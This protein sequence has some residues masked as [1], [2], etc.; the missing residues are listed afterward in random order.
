MNIQ[1]MRASTLIAAAALLPLMSL[2]GAARA[3]VSP[4]KPY[5]PVGLFIGAIEEGA[6]IFTPVR[7]LPF[8]HPE[9][10]Q[11]EFP[12]V[13]QLHG[14]EF[15]ALLWLGEQAGLRLWP[16]LERY[17]TLP[18][19]LWPY[20]DRRPPPDTGALRHALVLRRPAATAPLPG[21][22]AALFDGDN[23]VAFIVDTRGLSLAQ[24]GLSRPTTMGLDVTRAEF[25]RRV[26]R[27]APSSER[28]LTAVVWE[29]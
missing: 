23:L 26:G 16:T 4:E 25:L 14:S 6:R 29:H 10:G 27:G 2:R 1:D 17:P 7:L 13:Q 24:R 12:T 28:G 8:G 18:D 15:P 9:A 5:A 3:Q 19:S 11:H 21:L 22:R 20:P